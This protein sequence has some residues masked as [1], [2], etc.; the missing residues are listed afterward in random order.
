MILKRDEEEILKILLKL[1]NEQGKAEISGSFTDFPVKYQIVYKEILNHL[2]ANKFITNFEVFVAEDFVLT[3]LPEA[4][5]YF[6]KKN[7]SGN[8]INPA[9]I[10]GISAKN[11]LEEIEA[12]IGINGGEDYEELTEIADEI[13]EFCNNL[14]TT[15]T[16]QPRKVLIKKILDFYEKYPW[17][18]EKTTKVLGLTMMEIMARN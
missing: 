17:L 15:P 9:G 7:V 8:S 16:I 13:R 1:Y 10:V 14:K 4:L 3:L 12:L 11:V 2:Q 18:Q 5:N 6:A